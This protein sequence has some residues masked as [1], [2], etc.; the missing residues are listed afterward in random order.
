MA[1]V[2]DMSRRDREQHTEEEEEE[3][4]LLFLDRRML[5]VMELEMQ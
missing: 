3:Q 1:E 4:Q 2:E 5:Q